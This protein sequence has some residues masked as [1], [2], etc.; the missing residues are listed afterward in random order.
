MIET[1]VE[2]TP[3]PVAEAP[4]APEPVVAKP[5]APTQQNLADI[6]PAAPRDTARAEEDMLEIPAFLRRQAN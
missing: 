1:P 3:A 2:S 6:K 4:K 5:A